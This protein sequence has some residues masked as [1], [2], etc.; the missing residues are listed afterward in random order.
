MSVAAYL[1]ERD[2]AERVA[3]EASRVDV[4]GAGQD[5]L[6]GDMRGLFDGTRR[7]SDRHRLPAARI[8][9]AKVWTT[10]ESGAPDPDGDKPVPRWGMYGYPRVPGTPRRGSPVAVP[11]ECSDLNDEVDQL[12]EVISDWPIEDSGLPK[13]GLAVT[14]NQLA[15]KKA[16]LD[17]CIAQHPRGYQTQVVVR[18]FTK[19]GSTL[20]LPVRGVRW[21]LAPGDGVQH[22]LE[23]HSVE[24]QTISFWGT[25]SADPDRSIGV[26]FH[27]APNILFQGPLFRSG[28][29]PAL[30]P[31]S[32]GNQAG[33]IEIGIPNPPPPID[34][35]TI[36]SVLPAV[37][38]VLS[39][40]PPVSVAAPAPTLTL[41]PAGTG[42]TAGTATFQ[43]S[44]TVQLSGSP[45]GSVTIP[46]QFSVTFTITPSGD[47]NVTTRV[48][49]VTATAP[50][51]L[52]TTAPEPLGSFFSL[53]AQTLAPMLTGRIFD[54]MQDSV[55]NPAILNAVAGAFGLTN[56]PAGV[57]VSMR[58]VMILLTGMSFSPALGAFGGLF[59]RL[60]PFP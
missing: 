7:T 53:F 9:A 35:A 27:D 26:S 46:F 58:R 60:P 2:R 18:D 12:V 30:P 57:V 45:V 3:A 52:T 44:G 42:D 34:V 40:S 6:R 48:C 38:T 49:K 55:L 1:G 22:I 14:L 54:F 21:E 23:A 33:L 20:S 39:T 36:N 29:L 16:A 41:S 51:S 15:G 43:L 28:P 5:V 32:P 31:G 13:P 50:A 59:S 24:D 25:G 37:G 19:G 17:A 4:A 56:L 11:P 47:M 10:I 8:V